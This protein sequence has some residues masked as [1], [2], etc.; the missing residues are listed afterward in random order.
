M[1]Y[2]RVE[3]KVLFNKARIC[4]LIWIIYWC[5]FFFVFVVFTTFSFNFCL[6]KPPTHPCNKHI[7]ISFHLL[8]RRMNADND[9]QWTYSMFSND[10]YS[11]SFFFSTNNAF[12]CEKIIFQ[13]FHTRQKWP[14]HVST[15]CFFVVVVVFICSWW[16][17][18]FFK[19]THLFFSFLSEIAINVKCFH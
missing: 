13:L 4:L 5:C 10:N 12:F 7:I 1:K 11:F 9:G 6:P 14:R 16:T 3:A 15:V 8:L 2:S 17:I 18:Y 19:K